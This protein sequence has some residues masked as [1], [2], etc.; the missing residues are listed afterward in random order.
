MGRGKAILGL[1]RASPRLIIPDAFSALIS[2]GMGNSLRS[3]IRLTTKPGQ[4]TLT[5]IPSAAWRARRASPQV[6]TAALDAE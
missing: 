2:M 1:L 6:L 5:S 3:V 4:M